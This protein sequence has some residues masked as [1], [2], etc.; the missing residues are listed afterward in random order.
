M[1]CTPSA[2]VPGAQAGTVGFN[3]ST[4]TDGGAK[5]SVDS[6]PVHFAP[7]QTNLKADLS[8]SVDV[9]RGSHT[10]VV[11]A[12]ASYQVVPSNIG[13]GNNGW[14]YTATGIDVLDYS[15]CKAARSTGKPSVCSPTVVSS[16][17]WSELGI[18]N[19]D[20]IDQQ[21]R[22]RCETTEANGRAFSYRSF[23]TRQSPT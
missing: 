14:R 17:T 9:A 6:V 19:P 12:K 23:T 10:T 2:P 21:I 13:I 16:H 11:I 5:W 18:A 7:L 8:T 15:S 20:A 1:C 3:L 22:A 4:S